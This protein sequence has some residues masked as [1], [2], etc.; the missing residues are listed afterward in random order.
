MNGV[1]VLAKKELKDSFASPLVYILG[2]LFCMTMGWLFFNY[3]VAS[4]ELTTQTLTN[5]ILVPIFGNMNFV[6]VFL[7]PLLTMRLFSE[8]RKLHTIELLLTSELSINHIIWGKFLSCALTIIFLLG[9][10]FIFPI[11]LAFSGY[12]D[13]SIVIT[14]YVGLFL[15]I[16]CYLS[17]GLFSSS[18]TD[19]QI[20]SALLTF[21]ILLGIM[22]FV[23]T[24]NA[25]HNVL[26]GQ[27][28]QYLS[29]PFHFE[30]FVRGGI[31]NYNF[32]YF[33]S[34]IGFFL[35]LTHISL[36]SRKW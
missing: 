21:S 17:V 35:F 28:F 31:R 34:F 29:V 22:L 7:A 20:I 6:F 10:T 16:L 8:E 12:S 19:N 30:N 14:S 15:S 2:G 18:L 5:S 26:L 32:I 3:L 23:F 27:I 9:L 33:F 4:K 24:A 13:W 1:I 11:V 36:G 25:T